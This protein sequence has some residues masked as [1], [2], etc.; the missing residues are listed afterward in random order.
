MPSV[1][2]SIALRFSK[3]L[4]DFSCLAHETLNRDEV[5]DLDEIWKRFAPASSSSESPYTTLNGKALS[6]PKPF[7]PEEARFRR[8]AG[9]VVVR[10]S[11]DESGRVTSARDMCQGS[12][13]LSPGAL[14]SARNAKFEPA[15]VSGQAVKAE[16]I[17]SYRFVAQ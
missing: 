13:F 4:K 8:A 9:V 11:I 2:E 10:V 5:K 1:P 6:L 15:K 12:P 7:Y 14:E 17:I 16:G 3:R